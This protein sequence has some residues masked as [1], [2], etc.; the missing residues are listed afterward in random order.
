M[1]G[2]V[3]T[4]SLEPVLP[5]LVSKN[6]LNTQYYVEEWCIQ[7]ELVSVKQHMDVTMENSF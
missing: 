1:Y 4:I 5:N 7:L 6:V 3:C 2:E